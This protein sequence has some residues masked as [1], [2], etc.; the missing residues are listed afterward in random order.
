MKLPQRSKVTN[1]KQKTIAEG[2]KTRDRG[3]GYVEDS[4]KRADIRYNRRVGLMNAI[5]M[6]SLSTK[7][8]IYME[9]KHADTGEVVRY[10]T[11]IE[12][13]VSKIAQL[14]LSP[15]S[16]RIVPATPTNYP[17]LSMDQLS[18]LS[19]QLARI[20]SPSSFQGSSSSATPRPPPNDAVLLSLSPSVSSNIPTAPLD[21]NTCQKCKTVHATDKDLDSAWVGCNKKGCNYWI[22]SICIGVEADRDGEALS[23]REKFWCP[24]HIKKPLIGAKR[25]LHTR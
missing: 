14:R 24:K 10:S 19:R 15:L 20:P 6:L 16:D 3:Q 8:D 4:K 2:K 11:D 7:D 9:I 18:P 17:Q 12:E 5:R 22:H 13:M 23:L 1:T 25:K 21:V